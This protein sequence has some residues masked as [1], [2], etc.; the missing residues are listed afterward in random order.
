M[1]VCGRFNILNID[2]ILR[3]FRVM[4]TN[5]MVGLTKKQTD[6]RGEDLREFRVEGLASSVYSLGQRGK[7]LRKHRV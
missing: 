5:H 4:Q 2:L 7:D 1:R 6:Q 3:G